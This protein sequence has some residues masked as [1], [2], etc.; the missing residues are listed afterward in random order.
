MAAAASE[1]FP[2]VAKMKPAEKKAY[3]AK[4][5]TDDAAEKQRL[6]DKEALENP[7]VDAN[8]EHIQ[9]VEEAKVLAAE[10][11]AQLE[12]GEQAVEEK[13]AMHAAELAATPAAEVMP[14]EPDDGHEETVEEVKARMAQL[15]ANMNSDLQATD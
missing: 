5:K 1:L 8:G 14:A 7:T 13:I 10:M 6:K 11:Q 2:D 12:A 9:T 3:L 15:S 4:K